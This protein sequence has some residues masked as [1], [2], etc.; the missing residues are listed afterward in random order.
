MR[1]SQPGD[2]G[3]TPL[4]LRVAGRYAA[5]RQGPFK[6]ERRETHY[7]LARADDLWP[8][9]DVQWADWD[10]TGRLVVASN[11]GRLQVRT[12]DPPGTSVVHE[13]DLSDVAP[14]PRPAPPDARHW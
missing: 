11:D 14:D 7:A 4:E 6:N 8:L 5:F 12:V 13:V 1:K 9:A 10:G 3:P 2:V